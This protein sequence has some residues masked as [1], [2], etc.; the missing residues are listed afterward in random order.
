MMLPGTVSPICTDDCTLISC[1][2]TLMERNSRAHI[3][4]VC[5]LFVRLFTEI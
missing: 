1:D 4:G 5:L 3:Y 2:H